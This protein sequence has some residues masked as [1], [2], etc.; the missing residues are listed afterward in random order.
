M[1]S[2]RM[3]FNRA[4]TWWHSV[5]CIGFQTFLLPSAVSGWIHHL[6]IFLCL[7]LYPIVLE[8]YILKVFFSFPNS[9]PK[10]GVYTSCAP[11]EMWVCL[12]SLVGWTMPFCRLAALVGW[13]C[14]S[15]IHQPLLCLML[16]CVVPHFNT[17]YVVHKASGGPGPSGCL[18]E[19]STDVGTY[20]PRL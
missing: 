15:H 1:L 14:W 13:A 7:N 4:A 8:P 18:L 10:W 11:V 2:G 6:G 12:R 17:G 3:A 19:K 16:V 9:H 20:L 5:F